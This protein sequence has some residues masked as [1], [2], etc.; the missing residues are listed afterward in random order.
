MPCWYLILLKITCLLIGMGCFPFFSIITN[1]VIK[2]IYLP[3]FADVKYILKRSLLNQRALACYSLIK[4]SKFP[5]KLRLQLIHLLWALTGQS[6]PFQPG[7]WLQ[8][9]TS[10]CSRHRV[11]LRVNFICKQAYD[12][13]MTFV[14][15]FL[16][17]NL[18][19]ASQPSYT[20]TLLLN[21]ESDQSKDD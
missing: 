3:I 6:W 12:I 5:P 1:T 14:M 17:L 13:Q 11:T 4:S 21:G 15:V 18:T 8:M 16:P 20:P 7:S 9:R 19:M 2:I 10:C